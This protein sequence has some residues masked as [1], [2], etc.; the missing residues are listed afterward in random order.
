MTW[1]RNAAVLK[2]GR[3]GVPQVLGSRPARW[4]T[5]VQVRCPASC[6]ASAGE[7]VVG[8]SALAVW[9]R[10]T[11][12]CM[13]ACWR[14]AVSW[15]ASAASARL[16]SGSRSRLRSRAGSGR[17]GPWGRSDK[18]GNGNRNRGG[19]RRASRLGWQR[20]NRERRGTGPSPTGAELSGD[21]VW[22]V[23][24]AAPGQV[25][26]IR[27]VFASAS[28]GQGTSF[29][30]NS[31]PCGVVGWAVGQHRGPTSGHGVGGPDRVPR[32]GAGC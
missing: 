18:D 31:Q 25:E 2:P 11:G 6:C 12:A 17:V 5:V 24:G 4:R 23:A 1:P 3:E 8:A 20:C 15:W 10:S 21:L 9:S 28:P 19:C 30:M 7:G 29:T 27:Q 16:R 32:P 22:R 26:L 14:C 13:S